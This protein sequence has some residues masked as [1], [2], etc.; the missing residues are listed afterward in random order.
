M[1]V[2]TTQDKCA[3]LGTLMP[4]HE[5]PLEMLVTVKVSPTAPTMFT[6]LVVIPP[7]PQLTLKFPKSAASVSEPMN[8]DATNAVTLVIT[9]KIFM[10]IQVNLFQSINYIKSQ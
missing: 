9:L 8:K 4:L 7:N 6:V 3:E 5:L 2:P 1:V 10:P